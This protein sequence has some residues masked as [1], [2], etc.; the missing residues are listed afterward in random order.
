[1][2]RL[3]GYRMFSGTRLLKEKNNNNF[4]IKTLMQASY[5]ECLFFFSR[6]N[7]NSS[8]IFLNIPGTIFSSQKDYVPNS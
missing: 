5:L 1:M 7:G 6:G 2:L 8:P 3:V 4:N